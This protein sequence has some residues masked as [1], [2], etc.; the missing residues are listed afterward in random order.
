LLRKVIGRVAAQVGVE[1][2]AEAESADQAIDLV[3]RYGA[4]ELILDL[5]LTTGRG[6]DVLELMR[7][8]GLRCRTVVFSAFGTDPDG[9]LAAGAAAVIHKPDFDGLEHVLAEHARTRSPSGD[10]RRRTRAPRPIPPAPRFLSPSG[11]APPSD[12]WDMLDALLP[13]DAVMTIRIEG[14]T[15]ISHMHGSLVE[16]DHLLH[17]ARLLRDILRVQDRVAAGEDGSLVLLLVDGYPEAPAAV[18]ERLERAW[19]ASGALGRLR[20][21]YAIC[22]EGGSRR[23][24]LATAIGALADADNDRPIRGG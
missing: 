12:L 14:M 24:N 15:A 6:E 10:E 8:R 4:E 11:L 18:F 23:A 5:S 17:V 3:E 19:Q 22:T 9:L 20:A 1:V 13:G 2:V 7:Q 16:A 21:G